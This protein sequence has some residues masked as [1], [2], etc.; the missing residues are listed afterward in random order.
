MISKKKFTQDS[1]VNIIFHVIAVLMIIGVLYPLWFVIIASFSN[2]ADV[3]S[4]KVWFWPKQFDVRGYQK[5][6]EQR[7][8][9]KSYLN[10]ILYTIVGTLV[11]LFVT[12]T[13]GYAMSRK[14]L[15]GRKCPSGKTNYRKQRLCYQRISSRYPCQPVLFYTER[16]LAMRFGKWCYCC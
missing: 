3:A 14:D 8:I 15:P 9:W 10:T 1:V 13:A 7:Q 11:A 6:F 4:G 12:I 16:S 5:L 2:P